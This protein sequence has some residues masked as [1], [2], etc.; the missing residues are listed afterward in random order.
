MDERQRDPG[1]DCD[2]DEG[3]DDGMW[4]THAGVFYRTPDV[5]GE[6]DLRIDVERGTRAMVRTSSASL[7]LVAAGEKAAELGKLLFRGG[8]AEAGR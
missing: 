2:K 8:N 5:L 6:A 4:R 3:G 1:H 7:S